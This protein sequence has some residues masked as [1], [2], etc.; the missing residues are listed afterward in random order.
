MLEEVSLLLPPLLDG[1]EGEVA[2]WEPLVERFALSA[3]SS[4]LLGSDVLPT[5]SADCSVAGRWEFRFE[6]KRRGEEGAHQVKCLAL[7]G[8]EDI[9][10]G[11][12]HGAHGVVGHACEEPCWSEVLIDGEPLAEWASRQPGGNRFENSFSPGYRLA[13]VLGP[14]TEL[15]GEARR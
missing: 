4:N 5:Y 14:I 10:R 9:N 3:S 8:S 15:L 13:E 6:L 12:R 1:A 7:L 11:L 2:S